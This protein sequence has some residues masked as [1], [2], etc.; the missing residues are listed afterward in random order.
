MIKIISIDPQAQPNY[1][2]ITTNKGVYWLHKAMPVLSTPTSGNPVTTRSVYHAVLSKVLKTNMYRF[3]G[4]NTINSI[5]YIKKMQRLGYFN[6]TSIIPLSA[7]Y[8][9]VCACK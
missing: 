8:K 6:P 4:S 5:K 2:V 9:K 1:L 7:D 3:K